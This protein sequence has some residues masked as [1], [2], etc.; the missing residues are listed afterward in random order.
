MNFY[1]KKIVNLIFLFFGIATIAQELPPIVKYT[2]GIY[3]AG[4]QNW[5]ISEDKSNFIY[6]ANNEGLLEF[7]GSNWNLYPSPNETSIRCVK[8]VGERVYTGCYMEFGFWKRQV[9]GLLHYTSISKNI[10]DKLIEDEHFWNIIT[11]DHWV[12]F[13]SFNRIYIYNSKDGSFKFIDNH[14]YLFKCYKVENSIFFQAVGEGLYEIVN[15]KPI[16][17]SNDSRIINNR[18]V[19][20]FKSDEGILLQTE[21]AGIFKLEKNVLSKYHFISEEEIEKNTV[22]SAQKLS[23]GGFALGTISNGVYILDAKG[24]VQYHITQTTGISNNTILSIKEDSNHNL[25]LGLDNGID[26]VNLQ[27]PIRKYK[28][29]NGYLGTVYAS[30]QHNGKIYLGTNQGLFYRNNNEKGK[31]NFISGTKGQV[32]TLLVYDNQLFCG[33]DLGTFIVNDDKAQLIYNESGTWEFNTHPNH[34]DILVQG[35]YNG[36]S[37]LEKTNGNWHFRNK[38]KGFDISS[39]YFE[40]TKNNVVYIG[41]EYKGLIKVE[42]NK[43]VSAVT[44]YSILPSPQKGKNIGLVKYNGII[45]FFGK[46]GV[47]AL[48]S[49]KNV[50][51]KDIFLSKLVAQGGYISGKVSIDKSNK[52]WIFTKNAI[53]YITSVNFDSHFK[54]HKLSIPFSITSP[55]AGFENISQIGNNEYLIGKTDGYFIIN[56]SDFKVKK[57]HLIL[58][59]VAVNQLENA[60]KNI[61]LT[62]DNTLHNSENNIVFNYSIPEYDKFID[63]KYQ[64]QLEGFQ[65]QWSNWSDKSVAS[66]KNLSPGTYTFRVKAKVANTLASNTIAYTFTI[67][68]PWYSSYVAWI[69]YV[70][71]FIVIVFYIH[72]AYQDYYWKKEQKLIEENNLLLEIAALESEQQLIK[73]KNEQLAQDV[74]AKNKELAVSNMS[75][76]EKDELLAIIKE[77][78]KKSAEENDNKNLKSVITTISKNLNKD[79]SWNT[80]KESF[81]NVDKDFLKRIKS[82]HPSL[83]PSDLKLCAYLRLNLSSKEIAPMF[84][85]SIRSVEIKRYRLRKKLNL[86]HDDGLVDYI[87]R[88]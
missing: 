6:F 81:D 84:N 51:E 22:F 72:K 40:I 57:H 29:D 60:S 5:M 41:H 87:L 16:L 59:A 38:I 9:N 65:E 10:K 53:Y 34:K 52:M 23:H 3:G 88:V 26:C 85:I 54:I 61:S 75:L 33:H 37:V 68:R 70:L 76:I 8:V 42:L 58:N 74:D 63:V 35:N 71:L 67:E 13:Q 83:T 77:D 28:D 69:I 18:I 12:L 7:N 62:N 86:M 47:Y 31:F 48:N 82:L 55:M 79:D 25:W 56:L 14:P 39:R 32:W 11:V 21:R 24:K 50:F 43:E 64:Y 17:V 20:I 49:K 36:L 4:N 15:G 1:I 19:E 80:F 45:Y 73:L 66:F 78:L 30:V 27:S 46:E 44:N 2:S